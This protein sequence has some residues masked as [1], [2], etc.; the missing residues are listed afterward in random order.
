MASLDGAGRSDG[1]LLVLHPDNDKLSSDCVE[2]G[3]S[4][5]D[6]ELITLGGT[7]LVPHDEAERHKLRLKTTQH[8]PVLS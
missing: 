6:A 8:S 4:L 1:L 3:R 2:S 5:N 7:V